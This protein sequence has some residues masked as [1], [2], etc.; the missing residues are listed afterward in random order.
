MKTPKILLFKGRGMVSRLIRWQTNGIYSHVGLQRSDGRIIEAWHKPAKVRLRGR[1]SDWRDVEA[2][3]VVGATPEQLERA[4]AWAESQI[5]KKYDFGGVLR[6]VTRW[7][8]KQDDKWFCS[9]L[10]FQAF[11]EVDINLLDRI[12]SSQVSPTVLSFSPL[13]MKSE[14]IK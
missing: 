3:E 12:Q 1:L 6:F 5:G 10:V 11:K 14:P 8:K 2:Y 9:E 7:R 13:L 4:V